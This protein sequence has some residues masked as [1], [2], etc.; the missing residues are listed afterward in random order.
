MTCPAARTELDPAAV[1]ARGGVSLGPARPDPSPAF[2]LG[3]MSA[4]VNHLGSLTETLRVPPRTSGPDFRLTDRPTDRPN[5]HRP[6]RPIRKA[7]GT[8]PRSRGATLVATAHDLPPSV[9]L[10]AR[11]RST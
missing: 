4:V 9:K 2:S 10:G 3:I 7:I 11:Y 8:R 5:G 1:T 6:D